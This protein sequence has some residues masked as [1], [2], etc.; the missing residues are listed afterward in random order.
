VWRRLR[1]PLGVPFLPLGNSCATAASTGLA[2]LAIGAGGLLVREQGALTR[3]R[4]FWDAR[5]GHVDRQ[6]L[7]S[8]LGNSPAGYRNGLLETRSF[9]SPLCQRGVVPDV[10]VELNGKQ[11]EG[12]DPHVDVGKQVFAAMPDVITDHLIKFG[13]GEWTCTVSRVENMGSPVSKMVTVARWRGGQVSE[14][15]VFAG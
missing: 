1:A 2:K 4:R 11:T 15:Y 8:A 6:N 9:G 5:S 14:E 7:N 3:Y 12:T 10:I 13:D